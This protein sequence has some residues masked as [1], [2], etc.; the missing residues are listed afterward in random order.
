ML[1]LRLYLRPGKHLVWKTAGKSSQSINA[2]NCLPFYLLFFYDAHP[3]CDSPSK[4]TATPAIL[5]TAFG[6]KGNPYQQ[7]LRFFC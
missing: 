7:S 1:Q 2:D 3:T 4:G 6:H 5:Y